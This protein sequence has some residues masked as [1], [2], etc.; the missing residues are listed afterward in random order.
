MWIYYIIFLYS[1]W[2]IKFNYGLFTKKITVPC[3]TRAKIRY[4]H[5]LECITFLKITCLY[6]FKFCVINVCLSLYNIYSYVYILYKIRW[7]TQIY[8]STFITI[9]IFIIISVYRVNKSIQIHTK[10]SST[11]VQILD[12]NLSKQDMNLFTKYNLICTPVI[13]WTKLSNI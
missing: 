13:P 4:I 3:K 1:N 11:L 8:C 2:K 9:K 7:T 12:F 5:L 10:K 6:H